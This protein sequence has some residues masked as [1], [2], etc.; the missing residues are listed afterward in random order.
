MQPESLFTVVSPWGRQR[1]S[2]FVRSG[3]DSRHGLNLGDGDETQVRVD[4]GHLRFGGGLSNSTPPPNRENPMK[5]M[6]KMLKV[7]IKSLAEEARIIRLEEGRCGKDDIL[8]GKLHDHR[9][10][11]V[12]REQRLSLLAYAFL[13]G[14]PLAK[15]EPKSDNPP[16]WSRVGKLVEKFGTVSWLKADKEAQ[17]K[18]FQAWAVREPVPV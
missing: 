10:K 3:F 9:V 7:K 5:T 6:L 17:A 14:K 1:I 2:N 11:D 18:A 16:D 8:R 12:R 13:R 15:V 4:A